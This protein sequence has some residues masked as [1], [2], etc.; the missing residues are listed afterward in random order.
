MGYIEFFGNRVILVNETKVFAEP[1]PHQKYTTL[2]TEQ[3]HSFE[4]LFTIPRDKHLPS[5]VVVSLYPVNRLVHTEL[6][7]I[8]TK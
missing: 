5:S 6:S 1:Q 8:Y 4:F 2:T 3:I 7:Y